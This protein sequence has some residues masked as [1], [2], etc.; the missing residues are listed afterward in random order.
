MHLSIQDLY[1]I[2]S[3]ITCRSRS[4]VYAHGPLTQA[5]S[6][7]AKTPSR[8]K[9]PVPS[10]PETFGQRLARLR[11]EAGY[12]QSE[13]GRELG[14]S[15][16]IDRL[17]RRPLCPS[18][19]PAPLRPHGGSRRLDRRP[20]RHPQ[21]QDR[22]ALVQSTAVG[23]ASR[24]SKSSPPPSDDSSSASSTPSSTEIASFSAPARLAFREFREPLKKKW[25]AVQRALRPRFV[26]RFA[27]SR[28]RSFRTVSAAHVPP[29]RVRWPSSVSRSA[30]A[31]RLSPSA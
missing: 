30:M 14:V 26:P 28:A 5:P 7:P 29:R 27:A 18:A 12:S 1:V 15:Q 11:R 20:P 22:H 13:L 19:D 10:E 6:M 17:L 4:R 24:R 2:A 31:R 23:A 9:T 25:E 3:P 21:R 16:R 8:K